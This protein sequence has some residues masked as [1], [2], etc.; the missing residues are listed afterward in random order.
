MLGGREDCEAVDVAPVIFEM[1]EACC[2][3]GSKFLESPSESSE[4][5][6]RKDLLCGE[7]RKG[8]TCS[9]DSLIATLLML[10]IGDCGG[11]GNAEIGLASSGS[12]S[13]LR[14]EGNRGTCCI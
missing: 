4:L 2:S 5:D 3:F 6:M 12:V 9:C 1:R 13:S 7:S 11:D 8:T 14:V 10:L